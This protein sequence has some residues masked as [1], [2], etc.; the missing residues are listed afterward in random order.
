MS[1]FLVPFYIIIANRVAPPNSH[2]FGAIPMTSRPFVPTISII[3]I[4]PI[5]G[6]PELSPTNSL[7]CLRS[8][9]ILA[10]ERLKSILI[11]LKTIA[12]HADSEIHPQTS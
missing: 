1:I 11:P 2:H 5:Y 7:I 12:T 9:T 6:V 4:V 3:Q 10:S 8:G